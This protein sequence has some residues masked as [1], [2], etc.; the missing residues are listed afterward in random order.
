MAMRFWIWA[1]VAA[2]CGGT[3]VGYQ[4]TLVRGPY[5][6]PPGQ[7]LVTERVG[8]CEPTLRV[9]VV[10]AAFAPIE[11]ARVIV[12]NRVRVGAIEETLGTY[13]Y[14]ADPVVTDRHGIAHVCSPNEMP[15]HSVWENIGGGWTDRGAGQIDVFHGQRA[16]T[17]WPPF[18]EQILL[19]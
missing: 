17:L 2:G 8:Q 16:A 3:T 14:Q 1:L 6:A 4:R 19:R 10:D 15:P 13:E 12:S 18:K 5:G 9:R 11:G 7:P